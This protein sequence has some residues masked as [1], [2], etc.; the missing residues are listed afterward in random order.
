MTNKLKIKELNEKL[1]K[2]NQE[3]K[4]IEA[5]IASLSELM[6]QEVG[7]TTGSLKWTDEE[8]N[9]YEIKK[10]GDVIS[11]VFDTKKLSERIKTDAELKDIIVKNAEIDIKSPAAFIKAFGEVVD[12]N[13]VLKEKVSKGKIEVKVTAVEP[14]EEELLA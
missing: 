7:K 12:L 2:I 3:K 8:G 5:E 14:S 11:K 10:T 6:L 9:M 4:A 1:N 13:N